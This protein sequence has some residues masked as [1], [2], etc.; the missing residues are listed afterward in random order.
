MCVFQ[1]VYSRK[2][3]YCDVQLSEKEIL[4][5]IVDR[6]INLRPPVP[7]SC[8]SEIGMLMKACL[9]SEPNRRPAA[10]E[11]SERIRIATAG[12]SDS[13]TQSLLSQ[14]FPAKVAEALREG[15]KIE[16]TP[17]ECVT[18]FFSD[19]VSVLNFC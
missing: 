15:R 11:A 9:H 3:P 8:P 7:Q 4:S 19:I 14:I 10:Q 12:T 13:K 1:S 16:P 5:H 6:A 18:V 2:V 17:H